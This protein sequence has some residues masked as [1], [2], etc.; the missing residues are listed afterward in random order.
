MVRRM[1]TVDGVLIRK[2]GNLLRRSGFRQAD[3]VDPSTGR[4]AR[5]WSKVWLG[6]RDAVIATAEGAFAYR[7]WEY[8]FTKRT[9][10][11]IEDGMT[12]WCQRGD[13]LHVS[14]ALLT[15]DPPPGHPLHGTYR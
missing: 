7:V 3:I 4:D 1:Q 6:V 8:D 11:T 10:F 14:S 15:L 5:M 9:P 12:L 2:R 13:F